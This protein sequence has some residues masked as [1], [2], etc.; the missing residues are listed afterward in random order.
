MSVCTF[1]ASDH[2]LPAV[3]PE[4]DYPLHI[5]I[6][7]GE[8]YDGGADDNFFLHPFAEVDAYSKK[9]YGVWLEWNYT[10]GRGERILE[11]IR[12]A[13][14]NDDT[15]EFWHVWL[16]G[17]YEYDERPVMRE[18]SASID[19]LTPEDIHELDESEIW[20]NKDKNRPSFYRL[21]ISK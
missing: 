10:S 16:M 17:Y 13:L 5:N 20:N 19:E 1:I 3:R 2:P 7:T 4:R 15:V 9:R 11:Y 12:A 14:E 18:F 6:D 21:V 8:I